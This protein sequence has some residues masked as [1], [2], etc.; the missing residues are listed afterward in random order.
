MEQGNHGFDVVEDIRHGDAE[1]FERLFYQH[2]DALTQF[3]WSMTGS[4][5]FARDI[6]QDVFLKIW[7][8]RSNW[9][10]TSDIRVYLFQSVRNQSLNFIQKQMGRSRL[11]QIY[12][13]EHA[14]DRIELDPPLNDVQAEDA[15]KRLIRR[16]W[17][18]VDR[19]PPKRRTVFEL[20][21]LHGL[22]YQDIADV[23][24]ISV[25]TVENH[26]AQALIELR[27]ELS[28]EKRTADAPRPVAAPRSAGTS[29]PAESPQSADAL[30]DA[31]PVLKK[32]LP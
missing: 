4:R 8:N 7:R 14:I 3:A 26:I 32:I 20:H 29:R 24:G 21:K 16:I 19:M 15:A 28:V 5:E 31:R 23:C 2:H 30:H 13:Q 9:V 12:T 1:A 17:A 22:S 11:E 6:V 18:L 10:I 27:R 25:R